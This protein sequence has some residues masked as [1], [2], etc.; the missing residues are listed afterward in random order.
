MLKATFIR[1]DRKIKRP[2][3]KIDTYFWIPVSKRIQE[4]L[5]WQN[6]DGS[7]YKIVANRATR[8]LEVIRLVTIN[9]ENE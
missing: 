6:A 9:E 5:G 7:T 1:R 2:D 4:E 8:K 3:G